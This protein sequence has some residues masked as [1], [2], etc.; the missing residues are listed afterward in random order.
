MELLDLPRRRMGQHGSEEVVLAAEAREYPGGDVAA[1][2]HVDGDRLH[3]TATVVMVVVMCDRGGERGLA[4]RRNA[5]RLAKLNPG[6]WVPS[7]DRVSRL[8]MSVDVGSH[9]APPA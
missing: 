4:A 2:L 8:T 7:W 1:G 3:G 5:S 9:R 6:P